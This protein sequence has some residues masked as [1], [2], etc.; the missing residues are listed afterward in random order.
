[1]ADTMRKFK[2]LV[3][4]ICSRCQDDP[5]RLGATKL[6]KILWYAEVEHFLRTGKPLTG[7]RY[8][9]LQHGPAPVCMP[10]VIS[11]MERDGI[12]LARDAPYYGQEKREYLTL[13]EPEGIDDLFTATDISAL[14]RQIGVVCEAHTAKSISK[15]SH[16]KAWELAEIG[17]DLPLYTA[18]AVPGEFAKSDIEWLDERIEIEERR[19]A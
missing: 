10:H 1:M 3:H 13:A 19:V 9:K 4:Y 7:V 8:V 12:L 18:L 15:K 5:S 11:E 16:N 17:E 14:E 6:N 2:L